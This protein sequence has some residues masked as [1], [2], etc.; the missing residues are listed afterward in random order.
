MGLRGIS[1]ASDLTGFLAYRLPKG[2]DWRRLQ[3]ILKP[4]YIFIYLDPWQHRWHGHWAQ[5]CL[6]VGFGHSE[7][8]IVLSPAYSLKPPCHRHVVFPCRVTFLTPFGWLSVLQDSAQTAPPLGNF[9]FCWVRFRSSLSTLAKHPVNSAVTIAVCF[10][11]AA[12]DSFLIC[13]SQCLQAPK[14]DCIS[15]AQ[16][17][18]GHRG[19]PSRHDDC[20]HEFCLEAQSQPESGYL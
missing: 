18:A 20:L 7:H 3:C 12:T 8:L 1:Q 11:W 9:L 13:L 14:R 10:P 15:K 19:G 4:I 16:H 2:A 5:G 17:G 6:R